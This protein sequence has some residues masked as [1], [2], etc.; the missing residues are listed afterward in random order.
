[1][2]NCPGFITLLLL[3]FYWIIEI[4][5]EALM[6]FHGS[7][8]YTRGR[9]MVVQWHNHWFYLVLKW[10]K[11]WA[12]MRSIRIFCGTY[13]FDDHQFPSLT[14]VLNWLD[15]DN[16]SFFTSY[17]DWVEWHLL[18]FR[19]KEFSLSTQH[20]KYFFAITQWTKSRKISVQT[21][22]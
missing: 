12:T 9:H 22:C 1:M 5:Y 21:I 16:T 8:L 14:V 20:L 3:Q 15:S 13:P 11:H 10:I 7:Q 17:W 18:S 2:C 4:V 6:T 19:L